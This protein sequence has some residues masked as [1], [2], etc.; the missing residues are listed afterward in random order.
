MNR[1]SELRKAIQADLLAIHPRA[2]FQK[3]DAQAEFPYL[4]FDLQS[5]DDGDTEVF[6][7]DID[8]WD[9]IPDTT[10]LEDMMGAVDGD[11]DIENPSGL[12]R[13]VINVPGKVTGTIYR[14]SRLSPIDDDAR[15]RR[16]RYQYQ[17]RVIA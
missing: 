17:I 2:F 15:L 7:L 3:A 9:D 6:L 5:T 10:R 12:H 1:S 13:R 14:E 4:V 8:G 16:R 11:G